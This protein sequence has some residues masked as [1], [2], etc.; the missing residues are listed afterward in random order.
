MGSS[1]EL[2]AGT[3]RDIAKRLN[4]LFG[5]PSMTIF[6][7]ARTRAATLYGG[8]LDAA[9]WLEDRVRDRTAGIYQHALDMQFACEELAL[10]L[11]NIVDIFVEADTSGA[12]KLTSRDEI[13]I[14]NEV[15]HWINGVSSRTLPVPTDLQVGADGDYETTENEPAAQHGYAYGLDNTGGAVLKD[16]TFAID[17]PDPGTVVGKDWTDADEEISEIY[18]DLPAGTVGYDGGSF[19]TTGSEPLLIDPKDAKDYKPV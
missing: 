5:N 1:T 19:T 2:E 7:K 12:G 6:E 3:V 17:M 14:A 8:D 4:D 11:T 9:M 18:H 15:N 13:A 16:G 10:R